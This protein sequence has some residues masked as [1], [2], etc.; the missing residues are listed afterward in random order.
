MTLTPAVPENAVASS[1]N[2]MKNFKVQLVTVQ[3]KDKEAI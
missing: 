3:V 2:D 1:Y